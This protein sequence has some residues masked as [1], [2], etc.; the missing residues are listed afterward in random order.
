MASILKDIEREI[1]VRT[2]ELTAEE[3]VWLLRELAEWCEYKADLA[4]YEPDYDIREE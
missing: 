3:Y 4:E 1:T 2:V